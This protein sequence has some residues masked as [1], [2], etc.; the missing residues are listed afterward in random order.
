MKHNLNITTGRNSVDHIFGGIPENLIDSNGT[1]EENLNSILNH[2]GKLGI[3]IHP[4][5][6]IANSTLL[7]LVEYINRQLSPSPEL[8]DETIL[9]IG[10]NCLVECTPA[11]SV[12]F[13]AI[14]TRNFNIK[15]E[16]GVVIGENVYIPPSVHVGR[17]TKIGDRVQLVA[18]SKIGKSCKIGK[19][20][21]VNAGCKIGDYSEVQAC[22]VLP[23]EL[24]VPKHSSVE[25]ESDE[26]YVAMI[27]TRLRVV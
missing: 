19:N 1:P 6:K 13:D 23:P 26:S 3:N 16:Q 8:D 17:D 22:T 25:H 18:T 20:S 5:C 4:S 15:I 7:N 12:I 10:G 14:E 11:G 9:L 24:E 2:L 21:L 27:R